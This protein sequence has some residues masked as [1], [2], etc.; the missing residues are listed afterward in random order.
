MTAA[1]TDASLVLGIESSCDETAAAV[2][3]GGREVLSNVIA[4]QHELHARF[5]GVVPEIAS[6]SHVV[7]IL[8][9]LRQALAEARLQPRD[10]DAV[11]VTHR[12]GMIGCL[13]V[14]LAAAKALCWRFRLPLV[15]VDHVQ[16]HI[17]AAFMTSPESPLPLLALVASGGHTAMYRVDGPGHAERL[18]ATRDD[19]AGEALDKAAALL[20]LPYPGGPSIQ[21]AAHGGDPASVAFP[22]ALLAPDS[23]DFSFSGLKTALLVHLQKRGLDQGRTLDPVTLA[24]VAAAYQA[25]VVDTLVAKLARAARSCGARSLAIGGGVARN[26]RLRAEIQSHRDLAELAVVLPPPDLCSDNAAMVAG[27]G[28][29]LWAHGAP[30]QLDLEAMATTRSSRAP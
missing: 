18:G 29:H 13:L 9:I 7:R 6:R 5:R 28:A 27:L 23:L 16:A 4:S 25:A 3:R 10:L 30:S 2:V 1:N 12:P 8:P 14:G 24:D 19:A 11:A 22:R 20:G 26:E 17:H 15:G 21:A